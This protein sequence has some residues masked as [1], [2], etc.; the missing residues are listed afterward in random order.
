ML[1]YTETDIYK[2]KASINLVIGYI[3]QNAS[4]DDIRTGLLMAYDLFD[5]LLAE[6][7][8]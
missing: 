3:P 8:I 4:N 1:G 5:G 7:R 6:G 2:M